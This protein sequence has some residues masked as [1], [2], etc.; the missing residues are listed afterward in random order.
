M[1]QGLQSWVKVIIGFVYSI[2]I[3]LAFLTYSLFGVKVKDTVKVIV[4]EATPPYTD[5]QLFEAT[6]QPIVIHNVFWLSLAGIG[7]LLIL[8][9]FID[10]RF[11][12]LFVPGILTIALTIFL[13]IM[14]Y[15]SIENIFAH[16]QLNQELYLETAM[17][18]FQQLIAG[19][20]FLGIF[21]IALSYR[22]E[23]LK[24]YFKRNK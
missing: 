14:M 22:G 19:M 2:N 6:L 7:F 24:D 20:S 9:Y 16:V 17:N 8:L 3:L 15:F 21:L 12:V 10:Q 18:R 23:G 4:T 13:G 1:K 11:K 5:M